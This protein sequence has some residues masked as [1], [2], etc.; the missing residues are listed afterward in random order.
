M[1][2]GIKP[3]AVPKRRVFDEMRHEEYTGENRCTPCTVVNVVIAAGI[4]A[5]VALVSAPLAPVAFAVFGTVIYLR[6]YLVPGTPTFTKRYLPDR[7]LARFDKGPMADYAVRIDDETGDE[8][9]V[10]TI[11]LDAG[12]LEEADDT[13]DLSPAP[14]FREEWYDEM[15]RLDQAETIRSLAGMLD[16]PGNRLS[17]ENRGKSYA[18]KVGDETAGKWESD[19]ALV[20]DVAAGRAFENR[21]DNWAELPVERRSGLL[22]GLRVYVERCPRCGGTV[23]MTE[24]TVTS[25]CRSRRVFASTCGECGVRLFE[26][27]ASEVETA[28]A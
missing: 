3:R 20:A 17:T 18:V 21:V 24:E 13:S 14:D 5:L 12:A 15:D 22:R 9:D 19:Q 1:I 6:G 2:D 16:V 7:V 25:C 4:S 11:L 28:D 23:S 26:I 8:L 27:N 10:E